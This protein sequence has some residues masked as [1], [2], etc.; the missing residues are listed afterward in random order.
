MKL[1]VA[2][3]FVLPLVGCATME[4]VV[5]GSPNYLKVGSVD[6]NL[7][8]HR[9]YMAIGSV[10]L[11]RRGSFGGVTP[12]GEV[13]ESPAAI[14]TDLDTG[15]VLRI[16]T[17]Q[18]VAQRTSSTSST[19]GAVT[20]TTTTSQRYELGALVGGISVIDIHHYD[21]WLDALEALRTAMEQIGASGNFRVE[22]LGTVS[23]TIVVPPVY[24]RFRWPPRPFRHD[25]P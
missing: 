7:S 4:A 14:E 19:F 16:V 3:V 11:Y 10:N 24:F 18:P 17:L 6:A 25:Y 22:S 15:K 2:L 20:T 1:F 21:T 13:V 12:T 9:F 23:S 5:E 8:G